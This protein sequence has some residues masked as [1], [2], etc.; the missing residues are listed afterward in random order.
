MFDEIGGRIDDIRQ[1]QLIVIQYVTTKTF[2]EPFIQILDE[3]DDMA[4]EGLQVKSGTSP[5]KGEE[6]HAGL[7]RDDESS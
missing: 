6:R 4:L 7:N 2:G 5:G 1:Q 3:E